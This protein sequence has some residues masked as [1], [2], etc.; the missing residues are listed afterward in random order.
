[1]EFQVAHPIL[2]VTLATDKKTFGQKLGTILGKN[3]SNALK[4]EVFKKNVN[5]KNMPLKWYFSMKKKLER[6]G[7]DV[8]N[9]LW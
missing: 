5:N 3:A 4:I 2:Y 8:E 9:W 7:F 1:M 6:F